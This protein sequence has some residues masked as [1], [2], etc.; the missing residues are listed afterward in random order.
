METKRSGGKRKNEEDENGKESEAGKCQYLDSGFDLSNV[1]FDRTEKI[2]T[3]RPGTRG[4]V[5]VTTHGA[6]EPV[7]PGQEVY[8]DSPQFRVFE[9]QLSSGHSDFVSTGLTGTPEVARAG[10]A[11]AY[12][13][14]I[15][16]V[17]HK[18][19]HVMFDDQRE[20]VVYSEDYHI[21]VAQFSVSATVSA[22]QAVPL[23]SQFERHMHSLYQRS[24]DRGADVSQ[25][26]LV[27]I[28]PACV[29]SLVDLSYNA[30]NYGDGGDRSGAASCFMAAY[31]FVA[32]G[33][34]GGAEIFRSHILGGST[35][36]ASEQARVAIRARMM[37]RGLFM[38][39]DP[40]VSLVGYVF[41]RSADSQDYVG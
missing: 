35:S 23:W 32:L 36:Y 24:T 14:V 29:L 13:Q 28:W 19:R 25:P 5:E 7:F 11:L 38:P 8:V 18:K 6:Y 37:G 9:D 15:H 27:I 17:C 2:P 31:G 34:H 1:R 4:N 33:C 16:Q 20:R 10:P 40:L 41:L 30:E 12:L 21:L 26:A 39:F 3:G 22:A